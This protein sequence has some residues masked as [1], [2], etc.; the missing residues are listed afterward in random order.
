MARTSDSSGRVYLWLIGASL[1]LAALSLLLPSTPSYDPWAWIVWGHQI[2]HGSLHTAGGPSW[3][4]LPVIF[5]TIFAV[6]GRAAPDLWLL[7]ARA[8]AIALVLMTFKFTARV[9]IWLRAGLAPALLAGAIAVVA[10]VLAGNLL[11]NSALGYSEGLATAV[12]LIGLERHL[13]GHPRQAFAW[14]FIAALDRPEIWLFW[15]P[16][17]L[18]L[19][20]KDPGSRRLVFGLAL[21]TLLLWFV[22]QQLGGGS[23][24]SGV[25]RAQQPLKSSAAFA[26]CPFCSELSQHAWF[27]VP[28][29]VKVAAFL[30]MIA[31]AVALLRAKGIIG[32]R[33]RALAM[34]LLCGL[35][36]Y[37]WWVLIAIETQAGFSGNDRYLVTGSVFID[38]AGAI[39]YAWLAIVIAN[40][41][42][43]RIG[44][45]RATAVGT[46]VGALMFVAIPGAVTA[47]L[48]SLSTTHDELNYQ[49]TLRSSLSSL[50]AEAGG[51]QRLRECGAGNLMVERFQ[52]PMV[53][54]YLDIRLSQLQIESVSDDRGG[55]AGFFQ[56]FV[57][58]A[59]TVAVPRGVVIRGHHAGVTELGKAPWPTVIFQD[60]SVSSSGLRPTPQT[61]NL[62]QNL[63]AHYTVRRLPEMTLYED[64]Y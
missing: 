55:G 42:G 3:K 53:A 6:F 21:L 59:G 61:I 8:G 22:P 26:K 57:G 11:S 37:G 56:N 54:W 5:T 45:L 30:A 38:I 32:Q 2:L 60:R 24:T 14:G 31:A 9:T 50:I 12:V 35:F 33:G 40:W 52:L 10:V 16:Y 17:G 28:L 62:W 27:L 46:I 64:C 36:G 39:G 29:R 23:L 13:D 34:L 47:S 1:L 44:A 41:I 48:I 4:P 25:S 19:M 51:A 58:K 18:W 43:R 63:G 20:W 15:G 49:A 7:V